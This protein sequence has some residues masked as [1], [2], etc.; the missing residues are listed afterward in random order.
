M[1]FS[2]AMSCL[3]NTSCVRSQCLSVRSPQFPKC[4]SGDF[5]FSLHAQKA[6]NII[7]MVMICRIHDLL[8]TTLLLKRNHPWILQLYSICNVG[9][10]QSPNG[11]RYF[12]EQD[13]NTLCMRIWLIRFQTP[14]MHTL[15]MTTS[16]SIHEQMQRSFI[17]V[18]SGLCEGWAIIGQTTFHAL[19]QMDGGE[20][21]WRM[22]A[23]YQI[24]LGG[25]VSW[26][27]GWETSQSTLASS[28]YLHQN[29]FN[30]LAQEGKDKEK[31]A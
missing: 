17:I 27:C 3:N 23:R 2:M 15:R 30:K 19:W 18:I 25:T 28:V 12:Y 8:N 16:A 10:H 14:S 24:L 5:P 21:W 22:F 6:V 1:C 26:A 20:S 31:A 11:Q 13:S 7:F 4:S 9:N 29:A